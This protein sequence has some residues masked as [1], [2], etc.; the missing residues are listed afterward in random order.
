MSWRNNTEI[1]NEM[2]WGTDK[3][4]NDDDTIYT[5]IFTKINKPSFQLCP[6]SWFFHWLLCVSNAAF[7]SSRELV[8]TSSRP[9]KTRSIHVVS[10]WTRNHD[11]WTQVD[12]TSCLTKLTICVKM[13]SIGKSWTRDYQDHVIS[14]T[15]L[16][17]LNGTQHKLTS[18]RVR[19][20]GA[21]LDPL[22]P[23]ALS[24]C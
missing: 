17:D 13:R 21:T 1:Q 16:H 23:L 3:Y 9:V 22:L 10:S 7:L 2:T 19:I 20:T 6:P 4:D 8:F 11:R 5:D 15:R 18:R 12:M 24:K 14:W